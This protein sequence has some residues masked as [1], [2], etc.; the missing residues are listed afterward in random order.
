MANP[1]LSF[2]EF[3]VITP[4]AYLLGMGFAVAPAISRTFHEIP[5]SA[6][7]HAAGVG[8]SLS[9]GSLHPEPGQSCPDPRHIRSALRNACPRARSHPGENRADRRGWPPL[10]F[11]YDGIFFPRRKSGRVVSRETGSGGCRPLRPRG[12]LA[13][14]HLRRRRDCHGY[15]V[16]RFARLQEQEANPRRSLPDGRGHRRRLLPGHRR[17]PDL[18]PSHNGHGRDGGDF[19]YL[20]TR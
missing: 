1:Y 10:E 19:Q 15:D 20:Q 8:V 16:A 5:Q 7:C 18:C 17:R 11:G 2:L 3:L 13:D 6:P 14:Q 9:A 4:Y 12:G